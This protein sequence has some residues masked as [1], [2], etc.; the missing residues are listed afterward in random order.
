MHLEQPRDECSVEPVAIF[1]VARCRRFVGEECFLFAIDLVFAGV[2]VGRV[3]FDGDRLFPPFVAS[4][5]A[6]IVQYLR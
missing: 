2:K 1:L 4:D 6:V 5:H 3:G